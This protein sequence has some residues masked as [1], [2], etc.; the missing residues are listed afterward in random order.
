[1]LVRNIDKAPLLSRSDAEAKFR[2]PLAP[3]LKPQRTAYIP[4]IEGKRRL[5]NRAR[6]TRR[7][8]NSEVA[9]TARLR[10]LSGANRKTFARSEP[11][12]F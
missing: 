5:K 4:E 9:A 2:Y 10:P 12:R 1:M 11:Y 8:H 3:I 7:S 6:A